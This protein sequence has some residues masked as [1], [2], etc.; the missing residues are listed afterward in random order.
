MYKFVAQ[1]YDLLSEDE[2]YEHLAASI[3]IQ[4]I[5]DYRNALNGISINRHVNVGKDRAEIEKFFRSEWFR[6]LS[7]LDGKTLIKQ[8]KEQEGVSNEGTDQRISGKI[9]SH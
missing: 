8:L 3:I 4:A 6:F 9:I 7:D 2:A 5:E 1:Q